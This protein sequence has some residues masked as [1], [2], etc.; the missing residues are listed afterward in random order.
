M[1]KHVI[2]FLAAN[3]HGTSPLK[4]SEECAEIQR[5]LKLTLHR[6]D[7]HF[8]SRWAVGIDEL[9]RHLMELDPSVI[10][11]SG[12]GGRSTGVLLQ[13][14]QGQ[15]QV[16]SPRVLVMMVEAAA[17][18]PRVVVL[19]ACYSTAA[20]DALR[21]K[22]DCVVGMD[23][24]I[25]DHAARAFAIRFYGALGNRRSIG[26]AVAQGVAALAAKQLPD[27]ALPR[28][29]TRAG[30]DAHQ[31]YLEPF[32]SASR[33]AGGMEQRDF[34]PVAVQSP[35]LGTDMF[36]GRDR[37]MSEIEALLARSDDVQLRAALDGLPGI[38]K[39]ELARQVVARLSRG[40]KFPGGIFWFVAEH[41]DLRMQWAKIA[42]ELGAPVLQGLDERAAWAVTQITHQAQ[43]GQ[44]TL[45]VLDNVETWTLPPWPLPD[46]TMV[47]LL[48][49]TRVRWLHNSF[50]PYEVQPL[51]LAHSQQ[52]LDSIVGRNVV[53]AENLLVV[54]GGHVLSVELAGT[55]LRE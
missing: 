24:A 7:F 22:V 21:G 29:T 32:A 20:A 45:I 49:T 15:P 16:V 30:I 19:N 50:R 54:L 31:V 11:F 25:G 46:T 3:P 17:R 1:P 48:V 39:T 52:L 14:E 34:L 9:M 2:L 44:Q 13:D 53:G 26:N 43:R 36:I 8:E 18:N 33:K 47:R 40:D 35:S 38:G 27:E 23:G 4:L 5:E 12:H 55:Y 37:E 6:D 28:C 41:S 10:H 51:E 42:E